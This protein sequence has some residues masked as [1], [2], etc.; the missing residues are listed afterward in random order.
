MILIRYY[1]VT[2]ERTGQGHK[3][4]SMDAAAIFGANCNDIY[5]WKR[6]YNI[7]Y[8][9]SP[10]INHMAT[11]VVAKMKGYDMEIYMEMRDEQGWAGICLTY[12]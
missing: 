11:I 5:H 3:I 9:I 6:K 4:T 2:C 7:A 12:D 8:N 1:R 10:Y